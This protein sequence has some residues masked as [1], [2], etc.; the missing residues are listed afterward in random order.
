MPAEPAEPAGS[1]GDITR[2]GLST[3]LTPPL[4]HAGHAEDDRRG[5]GSC[6]GQQTPAARADQLGVRGTLGGV[7]VGLVGVEPGE[8]PPELGQPRG[9]RLRADDATL[10]F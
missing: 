5:A 8:P 3:V 9:R 4:Y 7:D 10:P 6:P 2:S 1:S